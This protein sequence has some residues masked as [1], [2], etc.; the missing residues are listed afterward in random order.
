[1]SKPTDLPESFA[2]LKDLEWQKITI[3]KSAAAV[4]QIALRDGN[5]VFLK[6]E[7]NHPLAELPGEIER[8]NWLTKMGFKSPR[9]IDAEQSADRVW[10]LM[11][12]VP[13]SDLTHLR[14]KP[15]LFI[16]AYSQ[17]LKRMHA[18][19]PRQCPFDHSI[20]AR[21]ALGTQRAAAKLVDESDF[22]Q[23]WIGSTAEDVI[24][25]LNVNRPTESELIVTHGDPSAPN[26]LSDDERF[27]GM[28][29]CTRL[30]TAD[31]WQDLSIACRSIAYNVGQEHV[32]PFL[33]LYGVEWN[34]EKFRFYNTL[35]ELY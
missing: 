35:D 8:L 26:I 16:R 28:V 5:S 10:L 17:G 19:D 34:A 33:D 12:A 14:D 21:I 13:G 24:A 29:D 20:E 15:E 2:P 6:S 9:V 1:M 18:L 23:D 3:G 27:S 7:A 22:D 25:W 32:R 11:S 31:V 4:W 30:G